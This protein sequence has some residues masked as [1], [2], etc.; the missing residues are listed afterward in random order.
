MKFSLSGKPVEVARQ[1]CAAED[2]PVATQ[3]QRALEV[4][5]RGGECDRS[6]ECDRGGEGDHVGKWVHP[7]HAVRI[8]LQ[9]RASGIA[10][11]TLLIKSFM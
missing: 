7:Q 6:G 1:Q 8:V 11:W 2:H 4:G 5:D 3:R 10:R 9:A